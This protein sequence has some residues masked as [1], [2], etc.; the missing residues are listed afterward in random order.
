MKKVLIL[1]SRTNIEQKKTDP[2]ALAVA[3]NKADKG[4]EAAW[5]TLEDLLFVLSPDK[6]DVIDTTHDCSLTGYDAVYLRYY[7]GNLAA[8]MA[9]ARFCALKNIPFVD[10]EALQIGSQGKLNQYMNLHELGVLFPSSLVGVGRLLESTYQTHGFS[11]PFIVKAVTGTRGQDNYLVQDGSELHRVFAKNPARAYVLQE[12]L[13]NDGDYRVVVMGDQVVMVIGRKATSKS[14]L[15]N[16]S[17]GGS[18]AI[19]PLEAL[20]EAVRAMSVRAAQFYGRDIAGVDIVRSKTDGKYYCLEVNRA[21]QIE[22]A[23]FADEKATL[24]A[25]YLASIVR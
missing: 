11:F 9:V 10:R 13:P 23:S 20:P 1:V 25:E 8:A 12:F 3:I 4:V 17:Q 21:P 7:S 16:T 6:A 15:N 5:A 18:A 22:Q 2:E 14:H 19:V 24:L